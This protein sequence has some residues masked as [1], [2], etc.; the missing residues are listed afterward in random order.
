[1]FLH[2]KHDNAQLFLLKLQLYMISFGNLQ[3][4]TIK[5]VI[6]PSIIKYSSVHVMNSYSLDEHE[7]LYPDE[8]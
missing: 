2:V 4:D 1:M 3:I 7:D 8:E 5:T 6:Y